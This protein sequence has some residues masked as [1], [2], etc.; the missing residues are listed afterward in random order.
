MIKQEEVKKGA[1]F[2]TER[3]SDYNSWDC[4]GVITEVLDDGSYMAITF[5]DFKT[6]GPWWPEQRPGDR[7]VSKFEA[8]IG[9]INEKSKLQVLQL[10]AQATAL[11]TAAAINEIDSWIE[12]ILGS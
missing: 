2:W 9:L 11:K 7:I 10:E 6:Y 3:D 12:R 8:Q 5:D 1:Y 4:A